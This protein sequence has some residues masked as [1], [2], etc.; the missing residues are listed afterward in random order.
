MGFS[1]LPLRG[2]PSYTIDSR[3][4]NTMRSKQLHFPFI[5]ALLASVTACG[6]TEGG[7]TESVPRFEDS[8]LD[9][10]EIE[11]LPDFGALQSLTDRPDERFV[12]VNM[13]VFKDVAT[14]EGF[15]GLT[16][17][18][19][20]TLYA[21]GLREAQMAIESRLIWAGAVQAQV[22]GSSD[23]VFQSM[24]L[25]EY[26]S[27]TAFLGFANQP[28]DNPEARSAGLEG[29]WLIPA[30]TLAE[31]GAGSESTG[32]A[33]EELP[34]IDALV[35]ATGF[36]EEQIERVLDGPED[37]PVFIV[38]LFRF[39]DGDRSTYAEYEAG[40]APVLQEQGARFI[41]RGSYDGFVLGA[42]GPNFDEQT[43]TEYP[44]R[45]A[46]L[47]TLSDPRVAAVSSFRDGGLETHWIYT[48]G[49]VDVDLGV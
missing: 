13:L 28:G 46:Y 34:A 31:G 39:T 45:A 29:Q 24:A 21:E 23:P 48:A 19:A 16:G 10:F 8:A 30:T 27:P 14:G 12:M 4:A 42:G 49:A 40:I 41:W 9:L 26:A 22:V 6:G 36:S 1:W 15:E 7:T 47:L 43:V 11:V 32:S 25:L 44:N 18:E 20:Y 38:E 3:T 37:E 2:L 33:A 5:V 17:R 35:E